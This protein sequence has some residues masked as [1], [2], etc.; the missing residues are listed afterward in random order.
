MPKFAPPDCRALYVHVPFCAAKC[1]YCDFYSLA[2]DA[3][4]AQRYLRAVAAE[5][6]SRC[7]LLSAPLASVFLG[8][9]TPTVLGAG[10]LEEL[11]SLCRPWID[12]DTE[13]SVEA[14]PGTL[15]APVVEVLAAGGVNRVSL[16]VQS[17]RDPEL[18]W[19]GRIHSGAE[20]RRAAETLRA[21]G[22]RDLGL[23]L[24]YGIPSQT[25]AS[26]RASVGEALALRPEHLSCYGLSFEPG[27]PLE[28]E[29][30][31]GRVKPMD[32]AAQAACYRHAIEATGRAGLEHYE[33]SNFARVGRRCRHNLTCWHNEP[34]LG[35][36]PGAASYVGGV[37]RTNLPDLE[38]YLA[39]APAG[40]PVPASRE[41]LTGRAAMAETVM[42][43]LRLIEGLHRPS[44]VRRYGRDVSEV[45]PR[46]ISRYAKLG[47]LEITA[48]HIRLSSE[49]L[50]V[51]D[52]V[53]A[54]ILAEA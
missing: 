24:I 20:A 7:A 30:R 43:S 48:S 1:R 17:F 45:F 4:V 27:T 53:L 9:G 31:A 8:G 40:R 12:R 21:A 41:R 23:D 42:L 50:F 46:S 33:I 11:L 29:L 51:A 32:E 2:F 44:F 6:R 15:D 35:V 3:P 26:W 5:L 16:G 47:A 54:D 19:L 25:P 39:A 52:T 10:L 37:R 49:A 28:R 34:Y 38:A 14:N 36:G 18:R 22:V 13:F